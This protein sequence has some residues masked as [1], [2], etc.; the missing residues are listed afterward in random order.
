MP[1]IVVD[2]KGCG[3]FTPGV[4]PM[5]GGSMRVT[6]A[7]LR[8]TT[9]G[10]LRFA[11]TN[12]NPAVA[13]PSVNAATYSL[14]FD[15]DAI[16]KMFVVSPRARANQSLVFFINTDHVK[17]IAVFQYSRHIYSLRC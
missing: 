14:V 2:L 7:A 3:C 9:G 16:S 15:A 6:P 5:F 13:A 11:N 8:A 12:I 1:T 17:L 10:T 4:H